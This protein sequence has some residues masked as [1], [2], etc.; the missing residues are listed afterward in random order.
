MGEHSFASR[1]YIFTQQQV[2]IRQYR[3]H[4]AR[5]GDCFVMASKRDLLP[6]VFPVIQWILLHKQCSLVHG[7]AVA[8]HGRGVLLPGWGGTGKTSAIVCLVRDVPGAAFLSDDYA[9]VSSNKQLLGFPKA[10][11]IYPYHRNLL[12]HAFKAR[13]KP[14]VPLVLSGLLER[15]R[16]AVRPA[17]MAFPSVERIARRITPEHM[18]VPARKVLPDAEFA[19]SAPLDKVLIV[20]R[21]SGNETRLDKLDAA[22]VKRRLMGNF[23]Y[24]IGRNARD[25]LLGAFGAAL[26]DAEEYFSRMGSVLNELLKNRGLYLL[27]MGA[28]PPAETGK[29]IVDAVKEVVAR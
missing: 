23:H 28:M 21:Y 16:T 26:L 10:F 1:A 29:A 5:D 2:F 11:F 24:E 25:C 7:A 13:H 19:D 20:E 9:I 3:L 22:D 12:P 17:I 18:Q 4:L 6:Y 27:R 8:V 14:L 15:V